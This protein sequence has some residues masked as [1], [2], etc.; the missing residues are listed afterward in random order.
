[1]G[2]E[3]AKDPD[4]P[5]KMKRT[6]V[7]VRRKFEPLPLTDNAAKIFGELKAKYR[8]KTAIAADNIKRHDIDFVLAST[9]IEVNATL[10]SVDGI[11]ETLQALDHRFR[12][13]HWN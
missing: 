10:V 1:M 11:F 13:E 3:R 6:I 8:K 12:W 2:K 7:M 9:T 5:E 4:T